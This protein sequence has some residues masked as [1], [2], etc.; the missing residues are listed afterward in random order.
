MQASFLRL[1]TAPDLAETHQMHAH[2][3]LLATGLLLAASCGDSKTSDR[4]GAAFK[5]QMESFEEC[6]LDPGH[7]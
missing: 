3:F 5:N 7:S 2:R 4:P 1:Q 6:I